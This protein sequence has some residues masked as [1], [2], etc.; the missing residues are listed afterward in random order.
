[1]QFVL[2]VNTQK[3]WQLF[4]KMEQNDINS[5]QDVMASPTMQNHAVF[6]KNETS[7]NKTI[8]RKYL[9]ILQKNK[10]TFSYL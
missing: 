6:S 5:D 10:T 2:N 1:M 7:W 9:N 8:K 3:Y 4:L